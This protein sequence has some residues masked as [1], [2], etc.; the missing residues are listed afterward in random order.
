MRP[1]PPGRRYAALQKDLARGWNTW[2]TRS[3]LSHVLL[4]EGLAL[5]LGIWE[6]RG[7][8]HLR[9]TLIGR[10]GAQE[11]RVRPFPR[12]D[13]G[14]YTELD[15]DWQDIRIRIQTAATGRDLAILVTPLANGQPT[16]P[17]LIA[18]A[19]LMWNHPGTVSRRGENLVARLPGRT[20]RVTA[21]RRDAGNR[22][23]ATASP[24]LA[25]ELA[26]PVGI[27]AGRART[28]GEIRALVA[29]ARAAQ[30][31]RGIAFGGLAG[32]H[33]AVKTCLAWNTIYDEHNGRVVS[34][35]SRIWNCAHGSYRL[36]CWDN[37]FAAAMAAIDNPSLACANAV[38]ITRERTEKG[39]VPNFAWGP[40]LKSR[41]RSQPPVG[42][43]TVLDL[44]RRFG[45]RWLIQE[46]YPAL[47][48]WNRWWARHRDHKG[49]LC[50]GSDPYVP[51]T[52]N[53]SETQGVNDTLGAALE[54]GLDNSPMYD[55]IP[56]NRRRHR[57]DLAD[58]GLNGMYVMDCEALAEI[59]RALGRR[60]EAEEL[61][62]RAERYRRNLG[63]LWSEKAGIFLNRRT[64]TGRFETRLSPTNFYAL[65]ARAATPRQADRMM[66]EH[67]YNPREF[68]GEWI[69]PSIARNDPAFRD[70]EYW[71]GRIWAPMNWLVYLGLLNYDL[72]EARRDLAEKSKRLLLKEWTEHGHVHEN[73]SAVTG[74]GCDARHSDR[75]YHWGGLLGL[76]ALTE[77]GAA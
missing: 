62:A 56:F 44:Y 74:E 47:L 39:F 22:L 29:A 21:T 30:E 73:Y 58:V 19:G 33:S 11:E 36:F 5:N 45:F 18:E 40:W 31:R 60:G 75:F 55:G 43:R 15:L 3:V 23:M 26:G 71:R 14:A 41:D 63:S 37:Y 59:S 28:P 6:R 42:S 10:Q 4:P 54:S 27:T 66:K 9:E 61:A 65:L 76:I 52:G 25:L 38:E 1:S 8:I 20:V 48:S 2:N 50:W 13:D 32:V 46:V 17:H 67:F 57:M 34:P 70:Q 7:G 35:V 77:A 69:M 49:L 53:Y 24:Y 12:T 64:D 51:V 16:T 72:P 68:W